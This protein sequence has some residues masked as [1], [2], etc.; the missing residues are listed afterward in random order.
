MDR[1]FYLDRG[2]RIWDLAVQITKQFLNSEAPAE[3]LGFSF[4]R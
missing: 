3:M 2:S 4:E 1:S